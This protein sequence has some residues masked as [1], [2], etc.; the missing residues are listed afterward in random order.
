MT[1]GGGDGRDGAT[2]RDPSHLFLPESSLGSSVGPFLLDQDFGVLSTPAEPCAGQG[3]PEN[4]FFNAIILVTDLHPEP[5]GVHEG[6][7]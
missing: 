3:Q 4:Y 1:P 2:T 7:S 5:P 6:L